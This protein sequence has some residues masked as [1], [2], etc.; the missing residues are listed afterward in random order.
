MKRFI[1]FMTKVT[2]VTVCIMA[3]LL[4]GLPLPKAHALPQGEEVVSGNAS[5][6]RQGNTLNV[7]TSDK[8][9]INYDSFSIAC[10]ETVNFFQPSSSSVALNRVVGTEPSAIFG[11]LNANGQIFIIN[12]NGI[13]FSPTSQVNVGGL[14]ASTL[15]I[16]NQDFLNGQ[17]RFYHEA[18]RNL[19]SVINEGSLIASDG[20]SVSLLGGAVKNKGLIVANLGSVN[21]A[22]GEV[23]TLNLDEEG[24][25]LA[26]VDEKVKENIYNTDNIRIDT[27][28]ENSGTI[29][30]EGGRVIITAEAVSG[31]FDTLINQEGII[32]ANS[33][34]EHNGVIRLVSS[35]EGIIRNMGT[36]DA[37]ALGAGVDGGKIKITGEIITNAGTIK[38]N[39]E[40]QA[41]AGDINMIAQ[42]ELTLDPTS[43]VEAKGKDIDS[44]GGN[45]YLYSHDNAYAKSGQTIDFSGGNISGDGGRGELSAKRLVAFAGNVV[46]RAENGFK[47]G[48]F[49]IDPTDAEVSGNITADTTV[50]ATNNV[51]IVGD[52]NIAADI[53]LNL[54]ADHESATAWD[55]TVNPGV[56]TITRSGAYTIAA[57]PGTTLGRT[58]NLKAGS[59]IG[60]GASPILT[61]NIVTL[62]AN[63]NPNAGSGSIYIS[64]SGTRTLTMSSATTRDGH[65]DVTSTPSLT[66]TT[67]TAGGAGNLSL[68]TTYTLTTTDTI[69]A[70]DNNITI[71]ANTVAIGANIN[72]GSGDLTLQPYDADRTIGL[73]PTTTGD[74]NLNSAELGRLKSSGTITLGKTGGTG[75]VDIDDYTF[76][77]GN[78]TIHGGSMALEHLNIGVKTLTLNS[79]GAITDALGTSATNITATTLTISNAS[80]IGGSGTNEELDTDVA[81]LNVAS[82]GAAY[83]LEKDAVTLNDVTTTD[84]LINI[85]TTDGNMTV[86]SVTAGGT[87]RNVTLTTSGTDRDII[88]SGD[89][90]AADD[91]VTLSVSG[92]ITDTTDGTT[93]ISAGTLTISTADSVGAS[94]TNNE[95]DT[96]VATLNVA[97]TGAV[98]ILEK[99][100]VTLSN[101]TSSSGLIDIET[102][103]DITINTV[104]AGTSATM[105]S[106]GG[107]IYDADA[108]LL[109]ASATSYLKALGGVIGTKDNPVNVNINGGDLW[110]YAS[111]SRDAISANIAGTVSPSDLLRI[112][113]PPIP[114]GLVLFNNR[115][116]G[117]GNITALQSQALGEIH[118]SGID[119]TSLYYNKNLRPWEYRILLPWELGIGYNIIDDRFLLGPSA[120]ID[121]SA[122]E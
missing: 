14:V 76:D 83:I 48:Y 100:A 109:S 29:S 66:V 105:V 89:I 93:D 71:T 15:N 20:G 11:A 88:M 91:T 99:D 26:V 111:G 33:I 39:A 74:F 31:I 72:A 107:S 46:G 7:T 68:S 96:D 122:I 106:S 19:S 47:K 65:I 67:A 18:G 85:R 81:T 101:V 97:S 8:V 112:G 94:G 95:L 82:T 52:T 70:T 120:L 113:T 61:K 80:S 25:I 49:L 102:A 16:A 38:A 9:I 21:L 118:L 6:D 13:L 121:T 86:T 35:S 42:K 51:T 62:S 34:V 53:T 110:V 69:T 98:Y 119:I 108:S 64:N 27:G 58:L 117:G 73:G 54:F 75:A 60:T 44:H 28:V 2:K 17:Y 63:L 23:I 84:G 30:A 50:W 78:I 12:P 37:S 103:G 24:L 115:L 40:D 114:P 77:Q 79:A 57:G 10:P 43:L 59:G 92:N 104:T 45:I 116:L 90:T 4:N 5:F 55:T 41:T 3:L 56:G 36:L 87:G 22:S 32:E 1:L